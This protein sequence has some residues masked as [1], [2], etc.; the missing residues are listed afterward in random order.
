MKCILLALAV[1]LSACTSMPYEPPVMVGDKQFLGISHLLADAPSK[2]VDIILVHGMCTHGQKWAMDTIT[3]ITQAYDRNVTPAF[4]SKKVM[5]QGIEIVNATADMGGGTLYFSA[6]LWSGLT[7]LDKKNVLAYDD[8]GTPNDCKSDAM[9]KPQRAKLNGQLKDGLLNDCLA[10]ALIYQ[11]RRQASINEAFAESI[12]AVVTEQ[13]ARHD[14]KVVPLVLITESLGSKM[15]FDA[16][17]MMSQSAPGLRGRQ[18]AEAVHSRTH[19]LYMGANQL[20]ILGLADHDK[21][22]VSAGAKARYPD[23]L[24]RFLALKPVQTD[25]PSK[26]IVAFSDPNDLLTYRLLPEHYSGRASV[27]NF[28]V[29]NDKTFFGYVENPYF[30]H[31]TY[32][33]ND[34]V[35]KAIV[36]GSPYSK[37]CKQ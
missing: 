34:R 28:L 19:Y 31:T 2:E 21:P 3:A 8:T 32:L 7:A 36:C 4:R 20:P 29:S 11:G 12:T 24:S 25:S 13:T 16:L 15:T 23:S 17:V 10:D 14:G 27:V 6:F 5:E 37:H 9:C 30:A 22:S 33:E 1:L 35:R 18:V 26:T